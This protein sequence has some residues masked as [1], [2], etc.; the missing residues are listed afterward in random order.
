MFGNRL[1]AWKTIP[2]SRL[3]GGT[4]V[5]SSP[6][7]STRPAVGIVEPAEDSQR[8]GL[9]AARGPEQRDQLTVPDLEVEAGERDDAPKWR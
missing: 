7:T 9:A 4:L 2:M 8:C 3:F 1:Y 5:T 6:S